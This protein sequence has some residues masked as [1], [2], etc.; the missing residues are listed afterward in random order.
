MFA[1]LFDAFVLVAQTS[2][3]LNFQHAAG[4]K[5]QSQEVSVLPNVHLCVIKTGHTSNILPWDK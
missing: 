3:F 2:A 1:R 4:G 5:L